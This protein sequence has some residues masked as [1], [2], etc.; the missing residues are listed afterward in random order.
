MKFAIFREIENGKR[1]FLL[2]CSQE[3]FEDALVKELPEV[4]EYNVR[5][6]FNNIVEN[7]KKESIRIP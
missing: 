1:K 4:R 2:E 7:F 5:K 6:A 3:L